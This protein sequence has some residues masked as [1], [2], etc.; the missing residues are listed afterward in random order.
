MTTVSPLSSSQCVELTPAE[1][2]R[3]A[4]F[5]TGKLG[6]KMPEAKLLMLQ[7]RISRRIRE[8]DFSTVEEYETY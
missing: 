5:V 3:F 4:D 7:G 1:F 8:L 6:I 2:R